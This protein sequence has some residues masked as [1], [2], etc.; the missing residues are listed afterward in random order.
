MLERFVRKPLQE[1]AT[2]FNERQEEK[3][4]QE[5]IKLFWDVPAYDV[6]KFIENA[7]LTQNPEF[8]LS[9]KELFIKAVIEGAVAK[10]QKR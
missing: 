9:K 6:A 5:V 1:M 2:R 3:A 7:D 8:Y 4:R 10:Q